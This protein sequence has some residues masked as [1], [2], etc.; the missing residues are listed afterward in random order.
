M[1]TQVKN[2]TIVEGSRSRMVVHMD[3][4][5]D[6]DAFEVYAGNERCKCRMLK[7][8]EVS[9]ADHTITLISDP[10]PSNV[11]SIPY[12]IFIK[13]TITNLEWLVVSG[14][15]SIITRYVGEPG[16]SAI[17]INPPLGEEVI[18]ID[19]EVTYTKADLDEAVR[20]AREA[21][22]RAYAWAEGDPGSSGESAYHWASIA[23]VAAQSVTTKVTEACAA[24][25]TAGTAASDAETSR[26]QADTAKTN[27]CAAAGM[28]AQNAHLACGYA[29]TAST[30]AT[31]AYNWAACAMNQAGA[32]SASA[33]TARTWACS[34]VNAANTAAG[35]AKA[36]CDFASDADGYATLAGQYAN[37][38]Q[39]YVR[40]A[41][42]YA[43]CAQRYANCAESH[44]L[45]ACEYANNAEGYMYQACTYADSAANSAYRACDYMQTAC[46]AAS[47]SCSAAR[48][49]SEA[50]CKAACYMH[51]TCAYL[52]EVTGIAATK[53]DLLTWDALPVEDSDN[54]V[55]SS[56]VFLL[57][58]F[59][60]CGDPRWNSCAE[61]GMP[62]NFLYQAEV[63]GGDDLDLSTLAVCKLATAE[64]WLDYHSGN[65][66]WPSNWYWIDA[67][68]D[69]YCYPPMRCCMV[70]DTRYAISARNDGTKTVANVQYHYPLY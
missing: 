29:T 14:N 1:N 3:E 46:G 66:I 23:E 21:A 10:A 54:P 30:K 57:T 25:S 41:C 11:Q 26:S 22:D 19:V 45:R 13:D 55:M 48:A 7:Y 5:L 35:S 67:V 61:C 17:E 4:S 36:A 63:C 49:A 24:A 27:A 43:N 15:I 62:Q 31:C 65:V 64:L 58:N 16:D 60:E 40:D 18:D 50:S 8:H 68:N 2:F 69:E 38:A 52:D 6:L 37:C 34:A 70:A 53:Q 9:K 51:K 20:Q 33:V 39:H 47:T 56:G 12:Q 59:P 44:M 28:S 32:A 42:N